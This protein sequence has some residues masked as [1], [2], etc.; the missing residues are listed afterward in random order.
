MPI[1]ISKKLILTLPEKI[2]I[3]EDVEFILKSLPYI[4]K[5]PI[6]IF[7]VTQDTIPKSEI[8]SPT[9]EMPDGLKGCVLNGAS[10]CRIF[11]NPKYPLV[12]QRFT[13][14]HEVG[15]I[16][17][18]ESGAYCVGGTNVDPE[19]AY[20]ERRA[21]YYAT[22]LL[23]PAKMVRGYWAIYRNTRAMARI[24]NVSRQAMVIRLKQLGLIHPSYAE[25]LLSLYIN[26]DFP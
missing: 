4:T 19:V 1:L 15:H 8:V 22:C 17:E 5:P 14:G 3:E 21:N 18:A 16:L 9:L 10:D 11:I 23:M 25:A 6:P 13:L 24:F 20:K 7:R 12:A 26:P 2:Q